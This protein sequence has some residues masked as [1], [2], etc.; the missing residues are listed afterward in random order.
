[1]CPVCNYFTFKVSELTTFVT[2]D[3]GV[4]RTATVLYCLSHLSL[5]SSVWDHFSIA[6]IL[7]I[8]YVK[9]IDIK[10][11]TKV[12]NIINK[13]LNYEKNIILENIEF[14]INCWINKDLPIEK[15]PYTLTGCT[16]IDDFYYKYK[17]TLIAQEAFL[18]KD[19][20]NRNVISVLIQEQNMSYE[21]IISVSRISEVKIKLIY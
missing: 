6:T 2:S 19:I 14:F 18:I 8:G 13:S 1:M 15:F 20:N 12:I 3:E 11:I 7:E 17:N 9:N 4:N 21:K 5:S 10:L 16:S